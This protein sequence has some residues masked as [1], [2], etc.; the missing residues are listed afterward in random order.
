MWRDGDGNV[1][2]WEMSGT[3]VLNQRA[4]FVANVAGSF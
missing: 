3:I 4:S 2:I 1:A